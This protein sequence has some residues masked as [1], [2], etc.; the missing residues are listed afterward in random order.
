MAKYNIDKFNV[1]VADC[2]GFLEQ[3]FNENIMIL[4]HLELIIFEADMPHKC[5]YDKIYLLL[6]S[7]GFIHIQKGFQNVFVKDD[8]V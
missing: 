4:N 7:N 5:N 3:F 2:E 1:L 6:Y 8:K